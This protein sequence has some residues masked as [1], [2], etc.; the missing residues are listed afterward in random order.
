MKIETLNFTDRLKLINSLSKAIALLRNENYPKAI[1]EAEQLLVKVINNF[2]AQ[3]KVSECLSGIAT[4]VMF[5]R[6]D[7]QKRQFLSDFLEYQ[8]SIV[9]CRSRETL[10]NHFLENQNK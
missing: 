8:S 6:N 7:K 5:L 9:E 2:E 4:E 1:T 10:I 3:N